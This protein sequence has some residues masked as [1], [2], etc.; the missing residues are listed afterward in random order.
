MAIGVGLVVEACCGWAMYATHRMVVSK[1]QGRPPSEVSLAKQ[2]SYFRGLY[3]AKLLWVG[4]AGFLG[5]W[6]SSTLLRIVF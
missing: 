1:L 2:E 5:F 6:L 4:F 3:L